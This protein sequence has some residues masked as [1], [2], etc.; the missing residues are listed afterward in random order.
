MKLLKAVR[1][2]LFIAGIVLA[3]SRVLRIARHLLPAGD[4]A[5]EDGPITRGSLITWARW[6][7]PCTALLTFG[8]DRKMRE[9]TLDLAGV[10]P[11]DRV[12]DIGC[13]TGALTLPAK[14][15]AGATGEVAGIDASLPM[16]DV[17]RRKAQ[18]RGLDV[19]F[20]LAAA[21]AL[22]YPDG[23]FDL[24]LSSLML[25]HLPDDVKRQAFAEVRRV[26]KPGGRFLA[27][28][29]EPGQSLHGPLSLLRRH[30]HTIPVRDL[31]PALAA[32]GFENVETG[33]TASSRLGYLRGA[34]P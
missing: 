17:A 6:Y 18:K 16:I 4:H 33:A 19:D 20:R 25:H 12:L 31:A 9:M 27:V 13:G 29:L 21:E 8:R 26:L 22:P 3:I 32:A 24:V 7:D 30:A 14:E 1:R 28:D 34:V 23:H 15:R 10:L 11:G 2:A 5:H